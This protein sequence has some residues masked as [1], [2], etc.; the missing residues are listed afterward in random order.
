MKAKLVEH[1]LSVVFVTC[2]FIVFAMVMQSQE[3]SR[4][5]ARSKAIEPYLHLNFLDYG[6]PLHRALLK[7][8]FNVFHPGR[9]WEGDSLLQAIDRI[10][11][12][13]FVGQE[14]KTGQEER[15]I[16][17][18]KLL[19]IGGM[20]IQFILLYLIVVILSYHAAQSLAIYRFV[21]MKQQR[22]SAIVEL[23]RC[24]TDPESGRRGISF[25][26]KIAGLS[27]KAILKGVSYAVLF[28]PAYVIG[29]SV[30]S[31]FDADSYAFMIVLG[32]ISNGLL[33][34]SA[35]KFFTLLVTES[36]KGYVQAA[37]VKNLSSSYA[38]GTRDGV[39]YRA[40]LRPKRMFPSHVFSHI[41]VNARYQNL[42]SLKEQASFL[43]TGLIIIEM[44]LNIQGHLGYELLQNILYRQYD[45]AMCIIVGI[46][47]IIKGTEVVVDVWFNIE[48]KKYENRE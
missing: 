33:I 46:F 3:A 24:F 15:G 4:E 13:Q 20:Y 30:R 44:A 31:T 9:P 35:N 38:W 22:T 2:A 41:F 26:L 19:K 7:E 5:A 14:Y 39:S 43:V 11:Q 8:S 28:A 16:S 42:L 21:K 12:E 23:Y 48:S 18:E 36:R 40:L 25:W 6:D 37:I 27:G 32:V 10:R 45:V 34:N 29:Y 47:L 17:P 1:T